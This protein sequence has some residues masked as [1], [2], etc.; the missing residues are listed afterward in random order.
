MSSSSASTENQMLGQGAFP[1]TENAS[2]GLPGVEIVLGLAG[3]G[4]VAL[5]HWMALLDGAPRPDT[6]GGDAGAATLYSPGDG[7]SVG[8][9]ARSRP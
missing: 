2:L 1:G 4:V 6:G 7:P 8:R 3:L 5:L 9:T